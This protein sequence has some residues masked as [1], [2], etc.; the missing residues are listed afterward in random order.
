MDG[1]V[2]IKPLEGPVFVLLNRPLEPKKFKQQNVLELN[3]RV[4]PYLVLHHLRLILGHAVDVTHSFERHKV[5]EQD[6]IIRGLISDSL[7]SGVVWILDFS[8]LW[9]IA[10]VCFTRL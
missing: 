2:G 5:Q 3:N 6:L 7:M 9:V 1:P 10:D 8:F 4:R